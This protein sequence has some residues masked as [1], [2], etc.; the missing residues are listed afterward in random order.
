MTTLHTVNKSPF[1]HSTLMSCIQVC[2]G[3]DGIL[4][5]EDGVFGG[6]KTAPCADELTQLI[7]KGV[8][9]F[10]LSTDVKAR[11]LHEKIRED[12]VVTDYSGFVQLSMEHRCVQSWY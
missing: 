5:L 9:I 1:T 10:A 11:G 6:L 12:I 3:N 8:K 2:G 4:L 7:Q